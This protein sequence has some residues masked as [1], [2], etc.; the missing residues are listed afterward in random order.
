MKRLSVKFDFFTTM[1]ITTNFSTWAQGH[2]LVRAYFSFTIRGT[3]IR[4]TGATT[5]LFVVAQLDV[6]EIIKLV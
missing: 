6:L 2:Y 4:A 5:G 1:I 3:T